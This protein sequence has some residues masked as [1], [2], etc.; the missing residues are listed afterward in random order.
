[1]LLSAAAPLSVSPAASAPEA[2]RVLRP[3]DRAP[4]FDLP[5]QDGRRRHLSDYHG[6]TVVLAFYPKDRTAG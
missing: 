5:N 2:A 1:M 6:H 3:G 4:D